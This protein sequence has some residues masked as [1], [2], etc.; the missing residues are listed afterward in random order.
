M[1]AEWYLVR[2]KAGA[3][4]MANERL[5]RFVDEAF[6][7]LMKVRVRRWSK[8]V[9]AI[10]P[11]FTCYLFAMFD[12]DHDYNHVHHTS[13]VQ[14]VVRSGVWPTAV[15]QWIVHDLRARCA[16]GP[17]E[18]PKRAYVP[19]EPVRV[20]GGPFRDFEGI[21]ERNLSGPERVAILLS[22]MGTGARVV[23]AGSMV[24]KAT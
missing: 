10:V 19:G 8:L 18:I 15:P 14:Y 4:R 12:L 3:E 22:A 1:A 5:T 6:L 7:P 2:T 11:L 23:M 9:D 24:E 17:I 20:V 21:F 16:S 13:G